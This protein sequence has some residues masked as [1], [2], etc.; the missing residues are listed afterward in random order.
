MDKLSFGDFVEI[1]QKRYRGGNEMYLHKVIGTLESNTWVDVP[2]QTPAEETMHEEME[3]VVRCICC[4]V[5]ETEVRKYRIKD[6]RLFDKPMESI[7]NCPACGEQV[8]IVVEPFLI[9]S[10]GKNNEV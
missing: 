5:C 7:V 4:G 10:G 1:E 8:R 3:P 9:M 6:V 2:V